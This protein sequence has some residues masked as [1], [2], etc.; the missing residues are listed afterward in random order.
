MN[1]AKLRQILEFR[2]ATKMPPLLPPKRSKKF[3]Y[4]KIKK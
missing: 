3:F 1:M 4:K 2:R